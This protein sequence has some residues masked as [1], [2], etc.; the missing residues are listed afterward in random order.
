MNGITYDDT[1]PDMVP[2]FV[3]N[4]LFYWDLLSYRLNDAIYNAASNLS[5][6][7][8]LY[9]RENHWA[10]YGYDDLRIDEV[11]HVSDTW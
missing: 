1:I 10:I 7:G 5:P 2:F 11:N 6:S 3:T 9:Q 8:G 4:F